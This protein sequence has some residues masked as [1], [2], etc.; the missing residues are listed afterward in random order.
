MIDLRA[1]VGTGLVHGLLGWLAA[2]G[3]I[4]GPTTM[5]LCWRSSDPIFE[6][7]PNPQQMAPA[8]DLTVVSPERAGSRGYQFSTPACRASGPVLLTSPSIPM[9][10]F[11]SGAAP[12]ICVTVDATGT[13][14]RAA[15]LRSGAGRAANRLALAAALRSR[16]APGHPGSTGL[17]FD[18]R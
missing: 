14:V 1:T 9:S 11:A 15:I 8:V 10:T 5:C 6:I 3:V 4:L 13:I 12:V 7:V 16:F 17:R 18:F 2:S